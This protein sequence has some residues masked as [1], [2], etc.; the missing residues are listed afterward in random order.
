MMLSGVAL[1]RAVWQRQKTL[2]VDGSMTGTRGRKAD[3]MKER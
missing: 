2:R 1:G 3:S